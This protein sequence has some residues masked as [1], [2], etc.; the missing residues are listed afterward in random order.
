[1]TDD[2]LSDLIINSH[3]LKVRQAE[4]VHHQLMCSMANH[5]PSSVILTIPTA[6]PTESKSV[7]FVV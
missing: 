1:M 6:G 5:L 2:K 3:D 7:Y 4:F